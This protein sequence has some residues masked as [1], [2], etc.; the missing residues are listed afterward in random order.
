MLHNVVKKISNTVEQYTLYYQPIMDLKTNTI[1]AVEA[2]LQWQHPYYGVY[3]GRDMVSKLDS[4]LMIDAITTW[5]LQTACDQIYRLKEHQQIKY[6]A[7]NITEKQFFNWPLV[8]KISD[9]L[10]Q[11][12]LDSSKLCVEIRLDVLK[13]NPKEAAAILKGLRKL[14]VLIYL[15]CINKLPTEREIKDFHIDGIKFHNYFS[16]YCLTH[17]KVCKLGH[18]KFSKKLGRVVLVDLD[19]AANPDSYLQAGFHFVQSSGICAP[20]DISTLKS[21][22][23]S[24]KNNHSAVKKLKSAA[25]TKAIAKGKA[26]ALPKKKA[27]IKKAK[28][29]KY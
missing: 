22:L 12:R 17:P 25:K 18:Q 24:K 29:S 28:K 3:P 27:S 5:T 6:I 4:D 1:V 15:D 8:A 11:Y 21:L 26:S 2:L 20:V 16:Q 10:A 14:G 13:S 23:H 19:D 9:A 7:I